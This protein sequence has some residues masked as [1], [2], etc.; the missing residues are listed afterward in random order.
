MHVVHL[1]SLHVAVLKGSD[2]CFKKSNVG[3]QQLA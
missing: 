1:P 2:V 3:V